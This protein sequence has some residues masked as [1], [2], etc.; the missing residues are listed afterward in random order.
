MC[1]IKFEIFKSL[2]MI[3]IILPYYSKDVNLYINFAIFELNI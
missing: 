3:I 1:T 2:F